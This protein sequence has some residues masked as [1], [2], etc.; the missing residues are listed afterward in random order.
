[1]KKTNIVEHLVEF[2][3][4]QKEAEVFVALTKKPSSTLQELSLALTI[5][6]PTVYHNLLSL[7][8]KGLVLDTGEAVKR[9]AAVDPGRLK[10]LLEEEKHRILKLEKSLPALLESL[11][12]F[13]G[14][15]TNEFIVKKFSGKNGIRSLFDAAFR[16]KSKKWDI[17]APYNNYLRDIDSEFGDYYLKARKYHG[18][19][20]RTLWESGNS[21]RKLSTE[22]I[23]LRNPRFMP[24]NM[25][26][27]FNTMMILYDTSVAFISYG[28]DGGG[29]IVT[30]KDIYH[31]VEAMFETIWN[32]SESYK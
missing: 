16:A 20:S 15:N 12:T 30:S 3:L 7:I 19:H 32:M 10:S 6:R 11:G 13:R 9:Y 8:T 31:I 27:K 1:M 26:N 22:D 14:G 29:V 28:E 2:G 25:T 21:T 23:K 5:K 18:I 4:S 24:K 17:I